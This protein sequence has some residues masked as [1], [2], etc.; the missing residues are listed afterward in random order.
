MSDATRTTI[1]TGVVDHVVYSNA[2]NHYT[3]LKF[4]DDNGRTHT[5]VGNLVALKPGERIRVEGSWIKHKKFGTQ[6]RVDRYDVIAPSTLEGIEK[7]LG[8]GMIKGI[9]PAL[10]KRLVTK[11]GERTLD[12]IE[13]HPDRLL[14]TEGIGRKKHKQIILAYEKQRGIREVMV[15]LQG[16]GVSAALA[17]RIF[18]QYGPGSI[19]IVRSNPYQLAT[20]VD[21]IGFKTADQIAEKMGIE[22]GS[23]ERA[24]AGVLYVLDR[25]M[26]DGHTC[27]PLANLQE[28]VARVL[29]VDQEL[30][31]K[32]IPDLTDPPQIVIE[33]EWEDKP[34][35]TAALYNAESKTAEHLVALMQSTSSHI[36]HANLSLLREAVE[37]SE[38]QRRAVETAVSN[39][40][41]II[42]GGPGVGKTTVV[43]CIVPILREVGKRVALACPTGRAAKRLSEATGQPASTIH[44]LLKYDP[45]RHKFTYG[46]RSPLPFDAI[47]I[48]EASMLDMRL[49]H[50]L[51]SAMPDESSLVLVG[52]GDQLPA[53]GPGDVL[54]QLVQSGKLPVVRLNEIFRQA[55]S[56]LIIRNAHRINRGEFPKFKIPGAELQDF[57]FIEKDDPD[58]VLHT[59]VSLCQT[60]LPKRFSFDPIRD[61][62]VI[63]PMHRGVVGV[64]NL[65]AELRRTLNPSTVETRQGRFRF[66]PRDKVMQIKN[67][68]DREVYNGDIGTISTVNRVDGYLTVRYEDRDVTYPLDELDELAPAYAISVH[69]SQGSEYPAVVMPL[70]TQHYMMLQRNLLY[71]AVTR[72]RQL[73]VI[74]GS[75]RAVG[76]AIRNDRTRLRHSFLAK[77]LESLPSVS[78]I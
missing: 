2:Q 7:Y 46:D 26:A 38:E 60:R 41:S 30:V 6:L 45:S 37:L 76:A 66:S 50:D 8:S 17:S 14:E 29:G 23:P 58:E 53:V 64:E 56:S 48:D 77:R 75:R 73:L 33:E 32:V 49:M 67:N 72:A 20:E 11:F 62:Q 78:N 15:F 25:L 13:N 65:N 42:T 40:V 1:V 24:K 3:V 55:E 27:F 34:V 44:R 71:T 19:S 51:L 74:V 36:P 12:I 57:Y 63:T 18:K 4:I 21:G 43:R 31:E 9:G 10:A 35:Y 52:D 47:I 39:K 61:I 16:Y 69:K 22:R 68:Y 28:E 5:V 70:V 54:R 59:V